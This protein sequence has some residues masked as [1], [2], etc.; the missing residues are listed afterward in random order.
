MQLRVFTCHH[1]YKNI[2]FFYFFIFFKKNVAYS[3]EL[4]GVWPL[5]NGR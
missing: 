3:A 5:P 4:S 2:I 1:N